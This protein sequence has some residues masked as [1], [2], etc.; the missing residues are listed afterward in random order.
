MARATLLIV[1]ALA[2]AAPS[3]ALASG[4]GNPVSPN[5]PTASQ[6]T[7]VVP[8]AGG[9]TP[10]GGIHAGTGRKSPLPSRVVHQLNTAGNAGKAAAGSDEAAAQ[11]GS[12]QATRA[13]SRRSRN[14]SRQAGTTP[15]GRSRQPSGP[16][17]AA[18]AQ[19]LK[20]LGGSTGGGAGLGFLLPAI[21]VISLVSASVVG[22][23]RRRGPN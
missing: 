17:S 8:T 22:V 21:L 11:A 2:L 14:P 23:L 15:T 1:L 7:E 6:Y 16:T 5:N 4:N 18:T 13:T 20:T 9:S 19:V 12:Q 3:A 10:S